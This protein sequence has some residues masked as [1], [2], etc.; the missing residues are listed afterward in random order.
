MGLAGLLVL[1]KF[2]AHER[3]VG[4]RRR[5]IRIDSYG[6]GCQKFGPD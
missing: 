2:L 6:C 4:P 5:I 1:P 3:K